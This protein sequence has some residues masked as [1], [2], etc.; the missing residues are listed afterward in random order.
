MPYLISLLGE[1]CGRC[2]SE[3]VVCNFASGHLVPKYKAQLCKGKHGTSERGGIAS[4]QSNSF[5]M[6]SRKAFVFWADHLGTARNYRVSVLL[7]IFCRRCGWKRCLHVDL[8]FE[9]R[10]SWKWVAAWVGVQWKVKRRY[11]K[12]NYTL[13]REEANIEFLVNTSKSSWEEF[14]LTKL[15][16]NM[17]YPRMV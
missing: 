15:S 9:A 7:A 6:V 5:P 16:E 4:S 11:C 1:P 12:C 2:L 10:K 14:S 17:N 8:T 3:W 13:K